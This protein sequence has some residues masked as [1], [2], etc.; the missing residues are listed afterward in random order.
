MIPNPEATQ[1]LMGN[2]IDTWGKLT[3]SLIQHPDALMKSQ[4]NYWQD[5]QQLFQN[6]AQTGSGFNDKRF[7]H[8]EWQNNLTLN[9]V[10]NA[11]FLLSN[12]VESLITDISEPEN[13]HLKQRLRFFTQQVMDAMAPTN[14]ATLNPEVMKKMHETNGSNIL[15]G[16]NQLLDDIEHDN[17]SFKMCDLSPFQLGKNIACTPGKVIYQNDLMQLIQY[18]PATPT[19]HQVPL[20]IVP[21]WI[22]KYYI[23]DL[24]PENSFVKWLVNQGLTVFMISWVNPSSAHKRKQFSDYMFEGPLT[25]IKIIQ[26]LTNQA[27]VNLLGY[28]VGGTLLGCTLAYLHKKKV[29]SVRSATFLTTLLDF[30]EPG[31]LGAFIDEEQLNRLDTYMEAK[32]YLDGKMMSS[33]FNALRA[34]DLIWGS[35]VNH[36]LKGQKPKAFDLLYWNADATNI[37]AKVH[38]FYL[39]NMYLHNRLIQ[40]NKIKLAGVPLDLSQIK[41]P[42]YFLAAQEDHIVPWTTC[43]KGSQVLSGENKFVLTSSG[44]VAGVVNP[45]CR[46]KYGYWCG[47]QD[48]TSPEAFLENAVFTSGSWWGDWLTWQKNYAGELAPVLKSSCRIKAI[49]QAPGSY[50]KQSSLDGA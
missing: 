6:T 27:Q 20:L 10:K 37:P 46:K 16:F 42:C 3:Q 2:L 21:P 44:H 12:H 26:D 43:Y 36:Y 23:L 24:Q 50:V 15:T 19:T 18:A 22:N 5:Y 13:H 47:G 39:R 25:A 14:F 33:V 32:G 29:S 28:C 7:N 11:Y 30:S 31:E 41:V 40:K 9:F 4:L 48:E 38:G 1:L 49:E 35:F 17:L 45:P 8:E 34:N